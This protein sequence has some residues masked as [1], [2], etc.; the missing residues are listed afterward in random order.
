LRAYRC[1]DPVAA[2]RALRRWYKGNL[3]QTLLNEERQILDDVLPNLFGY[4]LLQ[5][6]APVDVNLL[7]ASRV[8]HCMV[9]DDTPDGERGNMLHC[10]Y[11]EAAA[12]PIASDSVDVLVL[13]HT[14]EFEANPHEVLREAD[15]ALVP[16]GHV[17]IL[18]FS[19][20]SLWGIWRLAAGWRNHTPWCGRFFSSSRVKDWLALLGFDTVLGRTYFFRPP[21]HHAGL[22]RHLN[23]LERGGHRWWPVLGGAYVLVARK[24]VSTLTPIRPRWRATPRLVTGRITHAGLRREEPK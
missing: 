19:P 12:L 1:E 16:E 20:W 2:R 8:S 9:L 23:F 7:E 14:L 21:F 4:H 5:V 15:R 22:M 11:G 3:G 13:P 18:G 6:G 10:L 24:R 17:V